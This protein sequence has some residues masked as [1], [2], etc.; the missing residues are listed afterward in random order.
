[1][2]NELN[3]NR[4]LSST[5]LRFFI[6]AVLVLGIFFRFANLDS[7]LY[8]IDETFTSLRISGYRL[9]EMVNQLSENDIV[10]IKDLHQYQRANADKNVIGTIKGLAFEEPQHTPLYYSI[11]HFWAKLFGSSVAVTRSL[12]ALISLLAFPGIYWLCQELF[13]SSLTGWVAIALVAISPFQVLYAQEARQYS[14]WTVLILVSSAALLRA[15][16]ITKLSNTRNMVF[17]WVIYGVTLVAGIYTFLFSVLVALGHGI[18]VVATQGLRLTKTVIAYLLTSLVGLII[19]LPWFYVSNTNLSKVTSKTSW[20]QQEVSIPSLIENW[21]LNLSRL[22]LDL[23]YGLGAINLLIYLMLVILLAYSIYFL[24]RQTPAK[25]YLF[26]LILMGVTTFVLVLPDI[27]TG[28]KRSTVL[29]Y[30]IPCCLGIQLAVAYLLATKI[31]SVSLGGWRQMG[32]RLVMI[33]VISSG[34]VSCAISSQAEFRW[35]KYT[36][37]NHP[38]VAQVINQASQP[39]LISNSLE[40]MS[41]SYLLEQKVQF[42]WL[43]R[44]PVEMPNGEVRKQL[45][46]P[47]AIDSFSDVF[48]YNPSRQVLNEFE[49]Q[50][51]YK[52]ELVNKWEQKL[53]PVYDVKASLWELI[54]K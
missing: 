10:G 44:K 53:E 33:I 15:M 39:L 25:V 45:V 9:S 49:K 37:V 6:V 41:L 48:L 50:P 3:Q 38:Q 51:N 54:K 13:G 31:S 16:R 36:S 22:F 5:W 1:M 12:P 17:A 8:W 14:L 26:I 52:V 40:I 34:I 35:N 24:C 28:G 46:I 11:A 21:G 42:N 27:I 2:A 20:T 4:G 32:W 43:T 19:F 29:R 7:K 18:Y 47:K 23:D 30:F